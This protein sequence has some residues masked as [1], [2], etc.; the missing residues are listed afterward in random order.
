MRIF[1]VKR[2]SDSSIKQQNEPASGVSGPQAHPTMQ[3]I[4]GSIQ[5]S[6]SRHRSFAYSLAALIVLAAGLPCMD[7]AQAQT[8]PAAAET[9]AADLQNG[10]A[11]ALCQPQVIGNRRIPKES[12]LARLFSRQGN[13]YDPAIVERDFNSYNFV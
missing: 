13:L 8:A 10:N 1:T 6:A 2:A 5:A 9:Q 4:H 12:V 7:V 3:P 11:Q